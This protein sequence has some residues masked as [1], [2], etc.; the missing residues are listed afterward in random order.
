MKYNATA[1]ANKEAKD[2]SVKNSCTYFLFRQG[3]IPTDK[4]EPKWFYNYSLFWENVE[5][6]SP[7]YDPHLL[8]ECTWYNLEQIVSITWLA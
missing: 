5:K 1:G 8:T 2:E 3:A 7:D 6:L 4:S